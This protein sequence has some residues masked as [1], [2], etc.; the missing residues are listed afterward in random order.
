M[1]KKIFLF[2]WLLFISLNSVFADNV[3]FNHTTGWIW[4]FDTDTK[5]VTFY[6]EISQ[7]SERLSIVDFNNEIYVF[8]EESGTN[9]ILYKKITDIWDW[10]LLDTWETNEYVDLEVVIE[11]WTFIM[12]YSNYNT[13]K[14]MRW[15]IFN[16]VKTVVKDH[17]VRGNKIFFNW[18]ENEVIFNWKNQENERIY[19]LNLESKEEVIL[20]ENWNYNYFSIF[21][22]IGSYFGKSLT[23]D[24]WLFRW[25]LSWWDLLEE[26]DVVMSNSA[27]YWSRYIYIIEWGTQLLYRYDTL[28]QE[29]T[30]SYN[31]LSWIANYLFNRYYTQKD[32]YWWW[33][34]KEW[35]VWVG[36]TER[37]VQECIL[38]DSNWDSYTWFRIKRS[39]WN[40]TEACYFDTSLLIPW[41]TKDFQDVLDWMCDN[42]EDIYMSFAKNDLDF[43]NYDVKFRNSIVQPN[44]YS[45]LCTRP[46]EVEWF[47]F[48]EFYTANQF[49][50]NKEVVVL[51]WENDQIASEPVIFPKDWNTQVPQIWAYYMD[52][53]RVWFYTNFNDLSIFK[54]SYIQPLKAY[55][56]NVSLAVEDLTNK[57]DFWLLNWVDTQWNKY[58]KPNNP[59]M[60][61][62]NYECS[63]L[64]CIPIFFES[65]GWFWQSTSE[66]TSWITWLIDDTINI[67]QNSW[68]KTILEVQNIE[69]NDFAN[70]II[71]DIFNVYWSDKQKSTAVE[72]VDK[73]IFFVKWMFITILMVMWVYFFIRK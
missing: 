27:S 29:E 71:T 67:W 73:L 61:N 68:N 46:L 32:I 15:D 24:S 66:T 13:L 19:R 3:Y 49:P 4:V 36:I 54:D 14:F 16:D 10:I 23:W 7:Y 18:R 37:E 6:P 58:I 21:F 17:L 41:A 57:W 25:L 28:Q 43:S 59:K 64:D 65:L 69:N 53:T 30:I 8:W 50:D 56:W 34:E 40:F 9:K 72:A 63:W 51:W 12:Y 11:E 62:N 70:L 1:F 60:V 2:I 22:D 5:E 44:I 48:R 45:A 20:N 35:Y 55:Y 42:R 47:N 31:E 26:F 39:D 52:Q 38:Q 33:W